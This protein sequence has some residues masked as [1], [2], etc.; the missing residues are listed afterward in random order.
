MFSLSRVTLWRRFWQ[1][2]AT[3]KACNVALM[4]LLF[5]FFFFF[6]VKIS[7]V[8]LWK[9]AVQ[10]LSSMKRIKADATRFVSDRVGVADGCMRELGGKS[11]LPP[12]SQLILAKFLSVACV[13]CEG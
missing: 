4:Y 9:I 6:Q 10:S 11:G 1:P 8:R 13:K 2:A 12:Y 5:L 7:F 3:I